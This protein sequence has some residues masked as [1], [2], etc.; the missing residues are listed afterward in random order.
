MPHGC[1]NMVATHLNYPENMILQVGKGF[2]LP[3]W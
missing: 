3:T 2:T 1:L